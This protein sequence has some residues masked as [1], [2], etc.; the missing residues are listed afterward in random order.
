MS[1][2]AQAEVVIVSLSS[3]TAPL[4]ASTRPSIV[5]P[6]VT[7]MLVQG[8]DAAAEGRARSE[9]RRAA[10]LPVH[11]ARLGAVDQ[12]DRLAD[13][14]VSV[15]PAWKTKTAFGSPRA[16]SVSTPVRPIDEADV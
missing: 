8:D 13:A 15:E 16:S 2:S 6:V 11:V 9:R 3:V 14:V 5:T 1:A 12:D 4:R 10:D 7:V